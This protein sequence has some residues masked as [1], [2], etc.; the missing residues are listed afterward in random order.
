[1]PIPDSA[2]ERLALAY[3][4]IW[5]TKG[6]F[7]GSDTPRYKATMSDIHPTIGPY[8]SHDT[9]VIGEH[10]DQCK[11]AGLDALTVSWSKGKPN[12]RF[13]TPRSEA[14]ANQDDILE[15]VM[16][17]A[18]ERGMR[19]CIDMEAAGLK[20]DGL[21]DAMK[22]YIGR[23]SNDPRAPTNC[24]AKDTTPSTSRR[25]RWK[26]NTSRSSTHSSAT[27]RCR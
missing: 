16:T 15:S 13:H 4:Y 26:P 12:K 25:I 7:D 17:I 22:Y 18:H 2:T 19:C 1:M 10:M 5:F 24:A 27:R 9:D 21:Y 6:W 20:A 11:R 14:G 23:Y 3:Y 8:D